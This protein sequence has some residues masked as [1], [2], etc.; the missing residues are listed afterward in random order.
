MGIGNKLVRKQRVVDSLFKRKKKSLGEESQKKYVSLS[1]YLER[2]SNDKLEDQD[3]IGDKDL[4]KLKSGNFQ[5]DNKGK[6]TAG[7]VL[8]KSLYWCKKAAVDMVT[9]LVR[10]R[11]L[12]ICLVDLKDFLSKRVQKKQQ[13][14]VRVQ[15]LKQVKLLLERD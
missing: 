15:Q 2:A 9:Q 3:D 12:V 6:G 13:K 4:K 10:V 14:L 5:V 7:N 11:S 8:T 1:N